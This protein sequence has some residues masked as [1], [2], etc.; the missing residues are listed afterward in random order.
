MFF[1]FFFRDDVVEHPIFW[2]GDMRMHFIAHVHDLLNQIR[3]TFRMH[4]PIPYN[5]FYN[6]DKKYTEVTF[7]DPALTRT[8]P[9]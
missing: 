1:N 7:D 4:E 3:Y 5:V 8:Y 6:G 2:T 9:L